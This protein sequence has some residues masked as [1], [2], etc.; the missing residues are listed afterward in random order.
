MSTDL[1]EQLADREVPTPPREFDRHVHQRLNKALLA[2]HAT[3]LLLRGLAYSI[4]HFAQA[5]IH[6]L[7]FSITGKLDSSLP[8]SKKNP[9]EENPM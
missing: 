7:T 4:G 3:D 5:V 1:W 2:M 8:R 6:L 9:P